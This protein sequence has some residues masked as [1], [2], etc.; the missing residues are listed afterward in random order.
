MHTVRKSFLIALCL[1]GGTFMAQAT[2]TMA[3][4]T[5]FTQMETLANAYEAE[6]FATFPELG[7]F[8]G[9][10]GIAQDRFMDHSYAASMKWQA[11]ED[12]Y[13]RQL[14]N[15][16]ESALQDTPAYNTYRLLNE[17]LNNNKAARVCRESLWNIT[18]TMDGW[19]MVTTKVAEKQ[20]VGTP[21]YRQMALK[22]WSTF[23]QI[24]D[25]EIAKLK[26]GLQEGYSAPKPAVRIVLTQLK[27]MLNNKTEA[28]P[29]FSMALRDGDEAFKTQMKELIQTE[30]NPALSRYVDY[31]EQD[32]LPQAREQ[33]GVSALPNGVACYQ[34]KVKQQTTLDISPDAIHTFGLQHMETLK[35]EVSAI[36][37]EEFGLEDMAAIFHEAKTRPAYLFKSEQ[38]ILTY[39]Y[40]AYERAK[41]IMAAWFVTI[42][43]SEAIIEPY[44]EYRAKTGTSG[45]YNPPSEDG[46]KPGIYFI[47]TYNPTNKSRVDQEAILFH[48]LVPGHHLQLTVSYEDK[49]HLS[50]DKYLWNSGFGEG[51]ALYAERLADEMGLY[52]DSISRLGMLSNESL[53]TAR[54][55]VDPGIH[56]MHWTREQAIDY[57]KQHTSLSD[58]IIEGEVDRYIMSP[59]QATAYMLGKKE[60][61]DLRQLASVRE[62]FAIR[63]FHEQVLK[64]GAVTLPMLKENILK[65]LSDSL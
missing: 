39:N 56:V 34:A 57:L 31:L 20:P 3:K 47:N 5:A 28:S 14:N 8:W 18:S 27:I 30:I 1:L 43:K 44:P 4:K 21:E 22:R 17:H 46:T 51:W 32:Y 53:R 42:P 65:W 58:F 26:L 37:K 6:F 45:E 61:D 52:S 16:D 33:I 9:K 10:N 55:V 60:I 41:A 48:E 19:H 64:N 15:I 35:K 23:G 12:D 24:V 2:P 54:L 38:G 50:L 49:S 7:I 11:R 25:D 36:G 63:E 59:G 62:N 29:Y 13:L 40:A